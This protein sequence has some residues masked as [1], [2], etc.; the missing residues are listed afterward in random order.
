MTNNEIQGAAGSN[1]YMGG[2]QITPY[3]ICATIN[4]IQGKV[5][6]TQFF[7]SQTDYSDSALISIVY[8]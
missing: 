5:M 2:Y 4:V 6:L 7:Q 1:F 8:I 3:G